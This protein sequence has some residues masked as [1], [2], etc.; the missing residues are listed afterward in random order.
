MGGG[1][2]GAAAEGFDTTGKLRGGTAA[3][4]PALRLRAQMR[5]ALTRKGSYREA[6]IGTRG[7]PPRAEAKG[8]VV[9]GSEAK[10]YEAG[11]LIIL[12]GGLL[13]EATPWCA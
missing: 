2:E 3:S 4:H 8:S 10:G 9:K 5:R 12:R 13:A 6:I 11:V 7:L 1:A